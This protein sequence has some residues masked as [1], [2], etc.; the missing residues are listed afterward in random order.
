MHCLIPGAFS[1]LCLL[2]ETINKL[3]SYYSYL[4]HLLFDGCISYSPAIVSSTGQGVLWYLV[5]ELLFCELFLSFLP[6]DV[7]CS[8]CMIINVS[9]VCG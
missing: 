8:Y 5:P 4:W 9:V 1:F 7:D 2:L 3:F 6:K